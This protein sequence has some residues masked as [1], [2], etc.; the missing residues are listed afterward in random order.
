MPK[1]PEAT[2]Q[3]PLSDVD[4]LDVIVELKAGGVDMLIVTIAPFDESDSTCER[5]EQKLNAYLYAALH[6]NFS[7]NYPAADDGHVRIFVDDAHPI[8]TRA[9]I[10]VETFARQALAR[11]VV[12][13][14]GGFVANP[15][16]H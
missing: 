5:L 7:K 10:L 1:A 4:N 15:A 14:I 16:T 3:S 12:V 6:E 8:S 9:R 11:G 2:D 13:L